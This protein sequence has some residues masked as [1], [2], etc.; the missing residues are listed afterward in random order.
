MARQFARATAPGNTE[1]L[2]RDS[3]DRAAHLERIR[4]QRLLSSLTVF[5]VTERVAW[6]A[7][8]FCRTYRPSHSTIG[9]GDYLIAATSRVN[10]LDLATLNVRHFPMFAA[11]TA[12]FTLA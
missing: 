1:F 9:L 5:L 11:L 2:G 12:P 8:E 7:A 6:T 4:Q 10:G 3:D